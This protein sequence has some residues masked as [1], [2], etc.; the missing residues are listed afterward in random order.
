MSRVFSNAI[1]SHA[2]CNRAIFIGVIG[3]VLAIM[4]GAAQAA[5]SDG[6]QDDAQEDGSAIS[7]DGLELIDNARVGTAYINPN[8]DFSV[9]KR[10]TILEPAVSFRRNWLR[11]QNR[12]RSRNLRASDVDRIKADVAALFKEVF[13]ARL[14]ADGGYEVVAVGGDDVLLLRPAIINLDITAPDTKTAGRSATFTA[15]AGA[16][17]LY[18]ELFDSVTGDILGR[19]ADN[20]QARRN[21]GRVSWSNSVTNSAEAR[22]IF[23]RWAD[24]L[25]DFLDAH[26]MSAQDADLAA[27]AAE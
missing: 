16:A 15:T 18:I 4:A 11:D 24:I 3:V 1:Q 17:T 12:S 14:E 20:K 19:A 6:A 27:A 7:Y 10:V 23:G 2:R 8:A 25:R 21:G 22:R 26:Y 5:D 13:T 9:F